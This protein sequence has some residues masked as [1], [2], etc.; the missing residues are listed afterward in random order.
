M[1]SPLLVASG[2]LRLRLPAHS[3]H[4]KFEKAPFPNILH[5]GETRRKS[6]RDSIS[7]TSVE[8]EPD[9]EDDLA[10]TG[11]KKNI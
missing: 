6:V 4:G 7:V 9:N 11:R 8:K 3:C 5:E 2:S 10:V 1:A